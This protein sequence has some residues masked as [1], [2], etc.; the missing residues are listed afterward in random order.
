[1]TISSLPGVLAWIVNGWSSGR[2][3]QIC[4]GAFTISSVPV[5]RPGWATPRRDLIANL[6]FSSGSVAENSSSIGALARL[7][8][9][10]ANLPR[11]RP[12]ARSGRRS[13][14]TFWYGWTVSRADAEPASAPLAREPATTL[15]GHSR[16]SAW[17]DLGG[18]RCTCASCS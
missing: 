12:V 11:R 7:R 6:H 3:T 2:P 10:N 5:R 4:F 1:M 13:V 14:S 18:C 16:A 8:T 15:I 17:A 9:A